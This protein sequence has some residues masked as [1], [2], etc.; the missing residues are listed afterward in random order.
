MLQVLRKV[1]EKPK[2]PHAKVSSHKGVTIV[3]LHP[4]TGKVMLTYGSRTDLPSSTRG[5]LEIL[6]ALQAGRIL[7]MVAPTDW[8]LYVSEAEITFLEDYLGGWFVGDMCYGEM[9]AGIGTV[10][11]RMW[12]EG[13]T[14]IR[15]YTVKMSKPLIISAIVPI[16]KNKFRCEWY[17]DPMNQMHAEFCETYEGYADF[18]SC[19]VSS[20]TP[21]DAPLLEMKE[22]IPIVIASSRHQF[23]VLKQLRQLWTQAGGGNTSVLLSVDGLQKEGKDF[24]KVTQVSSQYK[25]LSVS[26]IYKQNP[27]TKNFGINI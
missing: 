11:G 17:S 7:V 9:W 2:S 16:G 21:R 24:A 14:I 5:L 22:Q 25:L 1:T 12:A 8:K 18:C 13:A 27:L 19:N 4:R 10:D 26:Y 3:V 20:I 23:K 15:N 6:N